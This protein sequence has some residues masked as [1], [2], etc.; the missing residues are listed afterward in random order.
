MGEKGKKDRARKETQK[1]PKLTLLEKRKAKK[2]KK[3]AK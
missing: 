3:G 2:E 1:E